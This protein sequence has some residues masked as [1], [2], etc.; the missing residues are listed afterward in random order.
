M[1]VSNVFSEKFF[2]LPSLRFRIKLFEEPLP[3]TLTLF[4][5]LVALMVAYSL[6]PS[7]PQMNYRSSFQ[8]QFLDTLYSE[9]PSTHPNQRVLLETTM[10]N[11]RINLLVTLKKRDSYLGI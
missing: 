7:M 6:Y 8:A 10:E 4:C 1:Y 5:F 2:R 9:N 11:Y 3:I